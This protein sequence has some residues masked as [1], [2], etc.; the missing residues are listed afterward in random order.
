MVGVVAVTGW[1]TWVVLPGAGASTISGVVVDDRG[2]PVTAVVDL[3]PLRLSDPEGVYFSSANDLGFWMDEG[4]SFQFDGLREGRWLIRARRSEPGGEYALSD[5][6][7]FEVPGTRSLPPLVLPRPMTVEGRVVTTL[8]EAAEDVRVLDVGRRGRATW[9]E[10]DG[11]FSLVLPGTRPALIECEGQLRTID[12]RPGQVVGGVEFVLDVEQM[13][14]LEVQLIAPRMEFFS[15]VGL[16]RP[17]ETLEEHHWVYRLRPGLYLPEAYGVREVVELLPGDRKTLVLDVR[18]GP[19]DGARFQGSYVID[20]RP[21]PPV[22][23]P[24]SMEIEARRST[25]VPARY[26]KF[27]IE[28]LSGPVCRPIHWHEWFGPLG[29]V[30]LAEGLAVGRYRVFAWDHDELGVV[31]VDIEPEGWVEDRILMDRASRLRVEVRG[32]DG[33]LVECDLEV[34]GR[35]GALPHR[36]AESEPWDIEEDP[37]PD[38]IGRTFY[39]VLPGTYELRAVHSEY[40][41]CTE[42]VTLASGASASVTLRLGQ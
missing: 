34:V 41:L 4:P 8:G 27:H 29:A 21:P 26:A 20:D 7:L 10:A 28:Q 40:G 37:L 24:G 32:P 6:V 36:V 30:E 1:A 11:A 38:S 3:I 16:G 2:A 17:R 23:S 39:P 35:F 14:E 15:G 5:P 22:E 31:E 9:T 18:G 19:G 33:Y 13:A 25:G 12:P 42:E